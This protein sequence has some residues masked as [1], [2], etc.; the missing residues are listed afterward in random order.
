M[1]IHKGK[2]HLGADVI[3]SFPWM[4]LCRLPFF[5]FLQITKQ[6]ALSVP[7]GVMPQLD[8]GICP[9]CSNAQTSAESLSQLK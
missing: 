5:F 9:N 4:I 7:A 3:I 1:C 2:T 8:L 6:E